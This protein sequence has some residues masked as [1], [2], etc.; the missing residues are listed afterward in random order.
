M[1][2]SEGDMTDQNPEKESMAPKK[3]RGRQQKSKKIEPNNNDIVATAPPYMITFNESL[4]K[5]TDAIRAQ[6]QKATNFV[7]KELDRV[8]VDK[9]KLDRDHNRVLTQHEDMNE[10]YRL[11]GLKR[12]EAMGF[13]GEPDDKIQETFKLLLGRVKRW[14]AKHGAKAEAM[15]LSP[16]AKTGIINALATRPK[17]ATTEDAMTCILQSTVSAT[18]LLNALFNKLIYEKLACNRF[19]FLEGLQKSDSEGDLSKAVVDLWKLG[20]NGN[21]QDA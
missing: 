8:I 12:M 5:H 10:K 9:Q 14:S 2:A 19:F 13:H 15:R 21:T 1:V 6:L 17:P 11:D 18:I 20:D 16:Q 7:E 3:P 4:L